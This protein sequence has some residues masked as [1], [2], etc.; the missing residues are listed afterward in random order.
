MTFERESEAVTRQH[1][2]LPPRE[3]EIAIVI[4]SHCDQLG[5]AVLRSRMRAISVST[6]G[7]MF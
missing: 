5:P 4:M 2:L 3:V 7:K 1:R 6:S